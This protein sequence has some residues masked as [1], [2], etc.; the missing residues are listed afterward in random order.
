M[1]ELAGVRMGSWEAELP[2]VGSFRPRSFADAHHWVIGVGIS[3][4]ADLLGG[5]RK[6]MTVIDCLAD[7]FDEMFKPHESMV[8]SEIGEAVAI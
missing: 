3:K 6:N 7:G 8:S 1:T 2:N 5:Q 4:H